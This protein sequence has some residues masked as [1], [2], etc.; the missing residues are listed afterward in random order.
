MHSKP[1][2]TTGLLKEHQNLLIKMAFVGKATV[3]KQHT[4]I[5]SYGMYTLMAVYVH[6]CYFVERTMNSNTNPYIVPLRCPAV[7]LGAPVAS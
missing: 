5:I 3:R 2:L 6:F 1:R 7:S 4:D